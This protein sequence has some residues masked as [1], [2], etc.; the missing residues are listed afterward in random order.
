MAKEK[1]VLLLNF[2]KVENSAS[3]VFGMYFAEVEYKGLLST[4]ALSEHI[5]SHGKIW[6]AD[7]VEG[8]LK[9]L[10]VCIPEKVCQGYGIKLDGIGTFYPTIRSKKGGVEGRE[11]LK[12]MG[13]KNLVHGVRIRFTPDQTELDNL[14]AK[15]F[16]EHWSF[17]MNDAVRTI[18]EGSGQS[19][20]KVATVHMAFGDWVAQGCPTL[21]LDNASPEP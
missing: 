11:A 13:I 7:L 12:K 21:T 10:K 2:R 16:K 18:Y 14:T 4:R 17:Q 9:Q 5:A 6:T 19:K 1:E 3:R 15:Q 8:V 20:T